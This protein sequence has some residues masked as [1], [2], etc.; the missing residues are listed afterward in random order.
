MESRLP[1]MTVGMDVVSSETALPS[2]AVRDAVNVVFDREGRTIRRPGAVS[3]L[4]GNAHSLWTS[5]RTGQ[6]FAVVDGMLN[7]L[8]ADGA[9]PL[10]SADSEVTFTDLVDRIVFSTRSAIHQLLPNG[11]VLPLT[12]E[13][14]GLGGAVASG[15][16]GL[17]AGRYAVAVSFLRGAE[18]GPLSDM[19]YVDVAEGGGI[20]AQGVPF[21]VDSTVTGVR[22][23]RSHP[24]GDV[25]FRAA[26]IPS[27]L[28]V[29]V[30]GA[31]ALGAPAETQYLQPMPPGRIVRNWRG[32]LLV[33]RGRSL[34]ISE[35]MRYGVFSPRHGF[36]QEAHPISLVRP[37]ESGVFVGSRAG[38]AF[39]RGDR[40]G[41]WSRVQLGSEAPVPNSDVEAFSSDL[42]PKL[43]LGDGA[44]CALWLGVKGYVIGT[45]DGQLMQPQARRMVLHAQRG[46]TA[47]LGR[48]AVTIVS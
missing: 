3:V 1:P 38:V 31:G 19:T 20:E 4:V 5:Q 24:G 15:A 36:I 2:G 30:L 33:A 10:A 28:S 12:L 17:H 16:G 25:M 45:A 43:E 47:L 39:Y 26:D 27:G 18:E 8:T 46:R 21:P 32:R 29:Y 9:T 35:P 41:D 42:S 7:L 14:P 37:V 6:T 22:L 40:P 11:A 13:K 44:R 34:L 23:Y 48:Q